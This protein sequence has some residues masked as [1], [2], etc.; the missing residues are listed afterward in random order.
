MAQYEG[1]YQPGERSASETSQ[2][3]GISALAIGFTIFAAVMMMLLGFFHFLQGISAVADGEFFVIRDRYPLDLD[4][5]TWGWL[6]MVGGVIV[7]LAGFWLLLGDKYARAVA[8]VVAF[9]S[10]IGNFLSIPYYPVWSILLLA[11]D[12]LVIWAVTTYSN[13]MNTDT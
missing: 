12:A 5:T 6:H 1:S 13:Y 10:A 8:V 11:L 4:V 9:L 3:T 7:M 2:G